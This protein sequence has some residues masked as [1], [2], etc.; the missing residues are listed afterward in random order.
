M[1]CWTRGIGGRWGWWRGEAE[2][3][4]VN[5]RRDGID[6]VE[7]WRLAE[8]GSSLVGPC[9]VLRNKVLRRDIGEQRA[10]IKF[11]RV[12]GSEY[13]AIKLV[14]ACKMGEARRRRKAKIVGA[15]NP[16]AVIVCAED[17]LKIKSVRGVSCKGRQAVC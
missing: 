4:L 14:I 2:H 11:P 1:N 5:R 10:Q 12:R 17:W 8:F 15:T 9:L 13:V 6:D 3:R 7:V 16:I